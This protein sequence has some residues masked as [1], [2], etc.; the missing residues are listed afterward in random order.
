[1]YW[2]FGIV[3]WSISLVSWLVA[4]ESLF[5]VSQNL[6]WYV[7][8]RHFDCVCEI[9]ECCLWECVSLI[10]R[11]DENGCNLYHWNWIV[12]VVVGR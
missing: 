10:V 3:T 9:Y 7:I 6:G 1:M 11:F 4:Y 12:I 2:G 8:V 5:R